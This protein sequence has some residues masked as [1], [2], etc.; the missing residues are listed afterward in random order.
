M[1]AAVDSSL[2]IIAFSSLFGFWGNQAQYTIHW[3]QLFLF[4]AIA[5]SGIFIGMSLSD[6]L[7]SNSLKKG[8]GWFV[9]MI[10]VA[11]LTREFIYLS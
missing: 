8:F 2:T 7:S 5:L 4:T 1:K 11:I 10:A 6:R 9:L 3:N